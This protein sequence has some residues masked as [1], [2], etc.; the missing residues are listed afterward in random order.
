MLRFLDSGESH[1]KAL[2]AILEGIPSNFQLDIDFINNELSRRQQG[3]GRGG[4]MK[5]EKDSVEIWCGLR[6]NTTTGNPLTLVIFNKDYENW[7]EIM[8]KEPEEENK[9]IIPRP[10]HGDLVGFYKYNTG[11]IRNSIERT[12]ARE[13]AIRTAVGAIC[14]NILKSLDI[15]IRS[16]VHTIGTYCDDNVDLFD[17]GIYKAINNSELRVYNKTIEEKVKKQIDLCKVEGDTLGG[18]I[19]LEVSNVPMGIGSYA[20]YDRKLD[21]ILSFGIMSVQGIKAVEFGDIL[22]KDKVFGSRF[23]DEIYFEKNTIKRTSNN[24][25]GIEAGISNGENIKITAFMKPIPTVKKP[26]KSINLRDKTNIITRYERSDVCGVVPASV[27]L[28]N[29]IAFE[30]LKEILNTYPS[31]DFNSLKRY[32][33]K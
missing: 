27:V 22:N 25:G 29:V 18:S 3:Y 13:T 23:N 17:N 24:A 19:K 4:R 7:K 14:K 10:G 9:I 1:G 2:V 30:L 20:H 16:K 8:N 6:G 28:E 26:L 21:A 32:L 11:D 31:D 12:S 5:I 15:E 33:N